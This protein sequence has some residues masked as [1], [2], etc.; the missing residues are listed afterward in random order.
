LPPQIPQG[1]RVA[2]EGTAI[3]RS[4]EF[5]TFLDAIAFMNRVAPECERLNHHPDWTNVYRRVDVLLTTHHRGAITELDLALAGEMNRLA[6][7][8]AV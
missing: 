6:G 3:E 1:W 2:Q 5:E 7:D 8:A 4:F